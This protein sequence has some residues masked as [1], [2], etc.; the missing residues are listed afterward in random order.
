MAARNL[1]VSLRQ[2]DALSVRDWMEK[3]KA[4]LDKAEQLTGYEVQEVTAEISVSPSLS[5]KFRKKNPPKS[6]GRGRT[7]KT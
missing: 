6:L 7:R 2:L 1:E 5:I 3:M 4:A